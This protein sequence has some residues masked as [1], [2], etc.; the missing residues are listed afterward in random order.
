MARINL[1][2]A[3][4]L[5]TATE[6]RLVEASRDPQ[7]S[8]LTEDQLKKNLAQARKLHDKWRDQSTRQRRE[9]QRAQGSRETDKNA[10]SQEKSRLFASVA[11]NFESRLEAVTGAAGTGARRKEAIRTMPNQ[12]QRAR[13]HRAA[14]NQVR[15]KLEAERELIDTGS[16]AP[17]ITKKKA[18]KKKAAADAPISSKKKS[19]KK[20]GETAPKAS[21]KKGAEPKKNKA[22]KAS[23]KLARP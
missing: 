8:Q 1:T 19:A 17:R 14:R 12:E 6:Y 7:L 13:G 21:Q 10:R 22:T 20:K 9:T 11:S 5:S 23:Q 18:A 15:E 2:K 3:R 16:A 4:E